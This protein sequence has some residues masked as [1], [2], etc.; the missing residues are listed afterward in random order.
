MASLAP[1]A[2]SFAGLPAVGA[3]FTLASNGRLG[4]HFCSASVVGST[5]GDLV[6]TAA[7]CVTG[8]AAGRVAFVPAYRDGSE[9]FGQF[10]VTNIVID[11][12]W[13]KT[14]DPD[15]DVA[16]LVVGSASTGASLQSLTGAERL[17]FAPASGRQ[18][19][20]VA[21]PDSGSSPISCE[22]DLR[23]FSATQS[24]FDCGG[25]TVGTSGGPL[26]L[27]GSHS[28]GV[29]VGVIGGFEQGGNTP[30][31]SYAARFAQNVK[32]L[33]WLALSRAGAQS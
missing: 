10:P 3:L 23:F 32:A 6:V 19:R 18:V 4:Q 28:P 13:S 21:Y 33:Y 14:A 5:K 25:Y 30:Q 2:V 29:V 1:N 15:D 22:N 20:A 12:A 16:F 27:A 24:E 31:V 26:L 9:P 8:R 7:H 11:A 17:G